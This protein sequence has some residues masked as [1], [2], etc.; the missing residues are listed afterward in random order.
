MFSWVW[1]I[2]QAETLTGFQGHEEINGPLTKSMCRHTFEGTWDDEFWL[3]VIVDEF[4]R[5]RYSKSNF[6][7]STL[8]CYH[9]PS[10]HFTVSIRRFAL[11]F[12]W[13]WDQ[14]ALTPRN[15]WQII[16]KKEKDF[17]L[18][19]DRAIFFNFF[20]NF[21][22]I[23]TQ[24]TTWDPSL[25]VLCHSTDQSICLADPFWACRPPF[26]VFQRSCATWF[27]ITF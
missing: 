18:P 13:Y 27:T 1:T 3:V 4:K 12:N 11:F 2:A 9:W 5:L 10:S 16:A 6:G 21:L 7:L 14:I 8:D 25:K 24:G 23:T 22:L 26:T 15:K 20:Y 19:L 17:L